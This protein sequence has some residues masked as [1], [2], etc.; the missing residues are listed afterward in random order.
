MANEI[1]E[2][3]YREVSTG[4]ECELNQITT[5]IRYITEQLNRTLLGGIIEIGKRF[6]RAKSLVRHGEW[7]GYV[8][9]CTG[10]SQSMA[11][12][13]IKIYKEYGSEQQSIFGDLSKSQSLGNLGVTKL[14]ELTAVPADEREDFVE[15]NNVTEE[16][17]VK[18]LQELIRKQKAENEDAEMKFREKEYALEQSIRRNNDVITEKQEEIERLKAELEKR[19]T[20]QA[21][22]SDKPAD[23]ELAAMIAE[24]EEKAKADLQKTIDKLE[25]DKDKLQK[26]VDKQKKQVEKLQ[27]E[28]ESEQKK[29]ADMETAAEKAAAEKAEMQKTIDRLKKESLLGS[30]ENMV[31]L[32]MCFETTQSD[33]QSVKSA[34]DKLKD[35]EQYA[36]LRE[37]ISKTL[38]A[39]VEGL[40]NE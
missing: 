36:K 23:G 24:A 40:G 2:A 38:S 26:S 34:L 33:I 31:R 32:N 20:E 13:Y 37:V 29:V 7:G 5:E 39:A 21:A 22:S 6:D 3:D 30:N 4:G 18:E 1:I 12:N 14:L 15:K 8:E 10:Y 9:S 25:K 17:T 28:Y 11:E 27:S 35:T 19:S 16:T